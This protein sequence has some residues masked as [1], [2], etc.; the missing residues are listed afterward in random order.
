MAVSRHKQLTAASRPQVLPTSNCLR[1]G[2]SSL[3]CILWC[4]VLQTL[5]TTCTAPARERPA[6][7]AH[8]A[9]GWWAI[10]LPRVANDASSDIHNSP[11]LVCGRLGC[12]SENGI[13][14]VHAWRHKSVD[15]RSR[16][17][18][19]PVNVGPAAYSNKLKVAFDN[20]Q[21]I[22]SKLTLDS[23]ISECTLEQQ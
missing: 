22:F 2:C 14:V 12:L 8:H 17:L 15:Q 23:K 5:H 1:Y 3:S 16:R 9:V 11:K 19:I 21:T 13:G 20:W 4:F 6:S 7:A 18:R 10:V